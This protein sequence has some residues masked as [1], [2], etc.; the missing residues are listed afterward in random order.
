MNGLISVNKPTIV[1]ALTALAGL[2]LLSSAPLSMAQQQG[3][4]QQMT[5]DTAP[6]TSPDETTISLQD[7]TNNQSMTEQIG[8]SSITQQWSSRLFINP[9]TAAISHASCGEGQ[10]AI[11]GGYH[12]SNPD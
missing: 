3:E 2:V 7:L 4:Q 5:A 11:G 12:V 6:T 9:D 8:G 10:L 1:A